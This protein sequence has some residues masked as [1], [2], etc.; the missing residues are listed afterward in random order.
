M[1]KSCSVRMVGFRLLACGALLGLPACHSS[2]AGSDGTGGAPATG[3][4]GAGGAGNVGSTGNGGSGGNGTGGTGATTGTGG[5]TSGQGGTT[6]RDA[7]GDVP[8]GTPLNPVAMHGQLKVVGTQLQDQSGNPVQLKGVSSQWLNLE[9]KTF[10]ESKAAIQYARDNW[11]LS[12]IRAAM[13][14][15]TSGGYLGTGTGTNANMSG[16]LS[17]V[18]TIVQNAIDLGIYVI[19]DWHTSDAVTKGGTTQATQ[20][21][22]FFTMMATQYGSSPNIIYEDYNEPTGVTWAQIVPYHQA[23]VAAIRM[24]DPDNLIVLGTPTWSQDVDLAAAAPLAGTNLLYTLHFYACTHGQ[25][26]IDKANTALSLGLPLFVTEF[27]A[28]PA[29]GGVTK[30]GDNDVCEPET[31]VWFAWMAQHN[32]SGASWKLDQCTDS[33]CILTSA[34]PID[35]PWTDNYLTQDTGGAPI[36]GG[37]KGGGHGLFVVNWMRE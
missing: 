15:D 32:I 29:D 7:A 5:A 18:N 31:N 11:K 27:G 2:S 20:A 14:V 19:V 21:S 30:S 25:S 28:T 37:E 24:V 12:V 36:D 23:V 26:L 33:S 10:P 3:G 17:K 22:A 16:M 4:T 8:L 1:K 13:G 9:S 35:G 6:A 34:A